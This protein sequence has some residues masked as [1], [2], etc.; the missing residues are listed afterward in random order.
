M[1]REEVRMKLRK[2]RRLY[3]ILNHPKIK[4]MNEFFE[5]GRN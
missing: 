3:L 2:K 1:E 5:E 4:K